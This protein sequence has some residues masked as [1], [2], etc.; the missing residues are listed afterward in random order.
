MKNKILITLLL[1]VSYL[2]AQ[3]KKVSYSFN[4]KQAIDHAIQNN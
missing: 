4:L 2:Q 1:V 3:E